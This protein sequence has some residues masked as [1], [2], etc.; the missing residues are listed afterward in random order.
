MI[1]QYVLGQPFSLQIDQKRP[2]DDFMG[3]LARVYPVDQLG[4][5]AGYGDPQRLFGLD[6]R[7]DKIAVHNVMLRHAECVGRTLAGQIGKVERVLQRQAGIFMRQVKNLV[8]DVH[9]AL[10][11]RMP[12]DAFAWVRQI[13]VT[14]TVDCSTVLLSSG[15]SALSVVSVSSVRKYS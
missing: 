15:D 2:G 8:G 10:R 3:F 1:P 9:G 7:D 5:L 14:P 4:Q 6:L 13:S 12:L 11:Q